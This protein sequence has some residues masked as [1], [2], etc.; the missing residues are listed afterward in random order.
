MQASHYARERE[1]WDE[2]GTEDYVS[3]SLFDQERIS[4]WIGHVSKEEACLDIGGG[5]GMTARLVSAEEHPFVVCMDISAEMLRHSPVCAVQGDALRLPF[6]DASFDLIIAAAF[7]HHLPGREAQVIG[8]CA[9]VL[10]PGGRIVGYDPSRRCIQNRIFMGEGPFRLK[11]FSPDERPI[12][13]AALMT[14]LEGGGFKN[15]RSRPFSFR[16]AHLTPFE[17]IQRWVLNPLSIGPLRLIFQ[18]WFFW[19]GQ[20]A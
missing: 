14:T 17:A 10:R 20:R 2:R 5:S 19:S 13:P 3:L 7:L 12:D 9:R 15:V 18:R 8:E 6:G 4:Q 16:N 1:Y 11:F